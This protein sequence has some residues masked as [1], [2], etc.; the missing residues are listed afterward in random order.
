[1]PV[2][3]TGRSFLSACIRTGEETPPDE[4]EPLVPWWS[5]TK[6]ALAVC[7]LQLV[8]RDLLALDEKVVGGPYTLRQLLQ[9]RAGVPEYGRLAAYHEAV[10]RGD[11]PWSV[12]DLLQRVGVDK[13][14]FEPDC[15]WS[16]SNVG[17]LLVRRIIESVTG[18]DI[19]DVLRRMIFAPLGLA[20][21]R[22]AG[23]PSDFTD[24]AWGNRHRY[25]PGWVYHGLL[26]GTPGDAAGFLH[27]LVGGQI[28]PPELLAMM[29]NPYPVG[30]PL[31]GRPW[32]TAGY[33]LGLMIGA[34]AG[35]GIAFGHSGNGPGSVAAVYH[36]TDAVPPCTVAVFGPGNDEATVEHEAVRLACGT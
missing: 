23:R 12:D 31:S 13:L 8:S 3:M 21:V 20:S 1:M 4:G 2:A 32:E 29:T 28:L 22:L 14:D 26:I 11:R 5:V 6:T 15:G 17:Y 7:A 33:G 25:D 30:G 34:M 19:G 18:D 24:T 35:A 10:E 27:A 36:F 16:Y 9:H